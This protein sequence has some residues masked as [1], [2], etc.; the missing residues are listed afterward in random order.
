MKNF[1][2]INKA[3]NI[4]GSIVDSDDQNSTEIIVPIDSKDHLQNDYEYVR[5][6]LYSTMEKSQ[7]LLNSIIEVAEDSNSPRAFEVAGQIIKSVGDTADKLID[8]QKKMKNI[9]EAGKGT[10]KVTNNNALFVGTTSELSK[11]IKQGFMDSE[12]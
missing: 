12:E 6:Q 4:E 5:A 11:L 9:E 1:D 7:Q 8:L 3:L 10:S 2:A